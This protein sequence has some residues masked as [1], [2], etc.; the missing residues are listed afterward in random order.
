MRAPGVKPGLGAGCNVRAEARTYLRSMRND[1][2]R[3]GLVG[4]GA[5]AASGQV[6][7][8]CLA[9]DA[10]V[11]AVGAVVGGGHAGEGCLGDG[12]GFGGSGSS[13]RGGGHGEWGEL[14]L[15]PCGGDA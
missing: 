10:E 3:I 8:G 6:V 12:G 7:G 2:P 4:F 15:E 14:L 13:R 1:E 11:E 5:A 9:Q